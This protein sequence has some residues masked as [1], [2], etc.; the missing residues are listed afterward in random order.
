MKIKAIIQVIKGYLVAILILL[1]SSNL[2][3]QDRYA[4]VQSDP[5][6]VVKGT[7]S[8]HDWHMEAKEGEGECSVSKTAGKL[9][10]T[11]AKVRFKAE[12]LESGKGGMDKNAYKALNTKEH[13][14]ITFELTAFEPNQNGK[15]KVKGDLT[16]AGFKRPT[17]FDVETVLTGNLITVSGTSSFKLTDFKVEPPTALLGTIKTGDDVTIEFQLTF[18]NTKQ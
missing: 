3:A 18:K 5:H 17:M 13:E 16:I 11:S 10:I 15:D 12:K 7:S 1:A 9:N 4:L 14:W 2:N 6:F 8:L